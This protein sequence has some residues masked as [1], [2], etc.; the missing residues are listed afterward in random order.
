[1]KISLILLATALCTSVFSQ[2]ETF[3][4]S[5]LVSFNDYKVLAQEVKAAREGRLVNLGTFNQFAAEPNTVILDTRS[6]SMYNA[7]HIKG[8]IHL[9]LSDFNQANLRRLI[10]DRTTRILIYCNNNFMQDIQLSMED[11]YFPSKMSR[12]FDRSDLYIPDSLIPT[13][14]FE[15]KDIQNTRSR[16]GYRAEPIEEV[17]TTPESRQY[18]LALNIPTFINL[19]GYGYTNVYELGEL[20]NTSDPNL[21]FEGTAVPET[22]NMLKQQLTALNPPSTESAKQPLIPSLL[23]N[24]E[25]Y[26]E[27]MAEVEPYREAHLVSLDRFNEMSKENTIILDFRSKAQ[28]D[29]KHVKGAINLDFTEFTQ[30]RLNELIPDPETKILIYCNNNFVTDFEDLTM[31]YNLQSK[32]MTYPKPNLKKYQRTL[33]L[34]IPA[35]INL[36]GYGFKN[37]YE[38][39]E[40]VLVADERVEFEGT[41]VAK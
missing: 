12:D 39:G 8:A 6:D 18:T 36:Y 35:Y 24:F 30:E 20:V 9:D 14:V 11:M 40:L 16:S 33:A 5:E 27:L 21:L 23:V 25:D 10:P 29:A 13:E 31:D 22:E 32:A 3:T 2:I 17:R 19:Y 41:A 1:M 38:L 28:Y 34:N 26:S 4:R 15:I 7:K 37:V